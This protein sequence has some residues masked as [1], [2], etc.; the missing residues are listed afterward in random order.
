MELKSAIIKRVVMTVIILAPVCILTQVGYAATEPVLSVEP[1]CLKAL[2]GETFTVN[3]TVYPEGAE[4]M[5]VEYKLYYDSSLLKVSSQNPG[6][7]LSQDGINTMNLVN[8]ITTPGIIEYGEMRT[9]IEDC[10]IITP[11]V[12]SSIDFEVIGSSGIS[13]LRLEDVILSNTLA[14]EIQNVCVKN[15]S[16]EIACPTTPFL[17]NGYVFYD[18]SSECLNPKVV[19]KN[20]NRDQELTVDTS[21]NANYYQCMLTS[22]IDIA[23]GDLLQFNATTPDGSQSNIILYTTSSEDI[24]RGGLFN[25][26][27]TIGHCGDVNCNGDVNMGDVIL[28]LNNVTKPGSYPLSS[29]WAGDVN[30]DDKLDM[31]DVKMLL[32]YVGDPEEYVVNCCMGGGES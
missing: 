9:G 30:C 22:C 10:G 16:V 21:E 17:I 29:S 25:F 6:P 3:I 1:S 7:F 31:E 20:S 15:G 19:I 32:N 24:N 14:E 28:I 13:E 5:G 8:N 2:P 18:N 23:A 12:V 11:G 27:L 26:N 4:V